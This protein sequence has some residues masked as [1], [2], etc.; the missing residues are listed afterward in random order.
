LIKDFVPTY[1]AV[2]SIGG[3]LLMGF[4]KLSAKIGSRRIP[5]ALL[6]MVSLVGGFAGVVLGILV[7]HHKTNKRSFQLKI[8]VAAVLSVLMLFLFGLI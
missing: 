6:L 5:E 8:F 4:D 2:V 7:F 1:L 3:L